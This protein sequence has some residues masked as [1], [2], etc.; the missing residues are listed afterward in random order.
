ML[1]SRRKFMQAAGAGS[2]FTLTVPGKAW[3]VPFPAASDIAG[4]RPKMVP[5]ADAIWKWM[6]E[7]NDLGP[8]R[9]TGSKAHVAF[10]EY[11]AKNLESFGCKIDRDTYKFP[12]WEAKNWG[13]NVASSSG[14]HNVPVSSYYPYS[15]Q[16]DKS[17][18]TGEIIYMEHTLPVTM[19]SYQ[20]KFEVP[21]GIGDKLRDK[22]VYTECY[23]P[24]QTLVA[25]ERAW[26]YYTPDTKITPEISAVF[27]L[28]GGAPPLAP[29][30][31]AGAKALITGWTNISDE[32]SRYQYTPF[33]RALQDFPALWVGQESGK[34][35]KA[36]CGTGARVTVV[37]EADIYQDAPTDTLIAT[38]PG[39]TDDE[40]VIVNSHT[41]G[42]NATEENGG[43][44]ILAI[45]KYFS[46]LP[47]SERKRSMLFVLT[48]G[49]F[50]SAY[51]P[52]IGGFVKQHPDLVKKA[53]ASL[54]VEH[55]GCHEWLD[56]SSGHYVDTGR[57]ELSYGWTGNEGI[58]QVM[59]NGVKGTPDRRV[60]II[61]GPGAGE[62]GALLR[63]GVPTIGY[64]TNPSFLLATPP[65][66]CMHMLDRKL[67]HGQVQELVRIVH[68]M[69]S[70]SADELKRGTW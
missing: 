18:V 5:S 60:A 59:L 13:V 6:V 66:G 45:A 30:K 50:A 48:T 49:H 15:G 58:A 17:G 69:Q 27:G 51:V 29:L 47:K 12:R 43:I 70:L 9:Y 10:V 63:A 61:R 33:G 26:R 1:I 34:K 56:N 55:L 36:A 21:A 68:Q 14:S 31:Q 35:L 54:T 22:I 8:N 42:T 39:M 41:D 44:G 23:V 62:G 7:A 38:L 19:A 52:S 11:L 46:E 2:A 25:Q 37:L 28:F 32:Q 40:I 65:D 53:V 20:M 24:A 4:Y 67:M 57:Q 64:Y 3:A 16:T